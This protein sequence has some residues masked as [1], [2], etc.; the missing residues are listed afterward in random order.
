MVICLLS[1]AC[2]EKQVKLEDI[3]HDNL[4]NEHRTKIEG[5]HSHRLHVP[6]SP[7]PSAPAS[8]EVS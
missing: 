5:N 2:A 1:M 6:P 8:Y 3:E 4:I 7:Q